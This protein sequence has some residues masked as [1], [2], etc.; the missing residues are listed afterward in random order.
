MLYLRLF[1]EGR[2]LLQVYRRIHTK[3][4]SVSTLP[5]LFDKLDAVLETRNEGR[6]WFLKE[7]SV[8][9]RFS[10]IGNNYRCLEYASRLASIILKNPLHHDE[11]SPLF[12]I[13]EHALD[14]W[15]KGLHPGIVYLK[16]LYLHARNEGFP[17]REDWL[18]H[19]PLRRRDKAVA[20][21]HLPLVRQAVTDA[22]DAEKLIQSL[23][24]WL[25]GYHDLHL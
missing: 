9:R 22:A 16:T 20:I 19:L 15:D 17:V 13:L 18:K 11:G 4:P 2:G 25:Q 14:A 10:G 7:Y 1:S 6:T 23:E 24:R 21:I 12:E 8:V 3:R 5:D